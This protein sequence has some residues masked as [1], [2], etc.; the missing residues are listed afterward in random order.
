M[1]PPPSAVEETT[2]ATNVGIRWRWQRWG[3]TA[4]AVYVALVV[5]LMLLEPLLVFPRPARALAAADITNL[6]ATSVEFASA[7][8]TALHG[9]L[10]A[11]EDSQR[12]VI[13]F[14][15]NGENAAMNGELGARLR[16]LWH[17]NVLVLDWRGYGRSAGTPHEAGI[18]ADGLAATHWL[19][20]R[21][22]VPQK[23][24]VL[25]GRSLGGGIAA[26][27]AEQLQ[28]RLLIVDRT[29]DSAVAVAAQRY[30]LFPVRWV[31]RNQFRSDEALA[32][33][34]GRLMVLFAPHDGSIPAENA[35]R[36][37][38]VAGTAADKKTLV[39]LD[40]L[41]HNDRLPDDILQQVGQQIDAEFLTP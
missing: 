21:L 15:G 10:F 14:H 26:Q 27:V 18:I 36:L 16:Q 39:S 37:F 23:E 9:W 30:A 3:L 22:D 35:R 12:A 6:G 38:D 25:F 11:A 19:A 7:D 34:E 41:D 4:F 28:S 2:V 5:T 20:S 13:Y 31:M 32:R 8:G 24:I 40:G 33:F 29:F 1:S 17:A